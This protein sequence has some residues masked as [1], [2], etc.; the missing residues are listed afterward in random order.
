M[1]PS[2][3]G[4]HQKGRTRNKKDRGGEKGDSHRPYQR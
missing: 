4:K 3:K 2:T 1:R